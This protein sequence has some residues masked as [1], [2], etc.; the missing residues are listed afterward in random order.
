MSLESAEEFM[1]KLN[2]D[3]EFRNKVEAV[4]DE[5][6]RNKIIK[7]AGFNFKVEELKQVIHRCSELSEKDLENVA[8]GC[9]SP[10]PFDSNSDG[11]QPYGATLHH[12]QGGK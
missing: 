9:Y 5:N 2:S 8:G 6:V 1:K 11:Y 4:K 12:N 3:L 10:T 7:E